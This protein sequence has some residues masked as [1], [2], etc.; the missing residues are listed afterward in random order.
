MPAL[1]IYI[2][3]LIISGLA[4]FSLTFFLSGLKNRAGMIAIPN[5]RSLHEK[6]VPKSGGIAIVI[7]WYAGLT[8]LFLNDFIEKNLYCAL[9][10][11]VL[12]S[13]V[14][15]LDDIY[16]VKPVLRL[17]IH[18]ISAVIAFS[19]LGGLRPLFIPEIHFNYNWI[20]YPIAII[21]IVWFIN[22]FNFMDGV[23]GYASVEAIFISSVFFIMSWNPASVLLIVCV[24]GFLIW[25][26]PK[27]RIFMGDTGSTQLGF[28]LV[29]SGIYFHNTLEFSILNWI[30]LTS[31]FWFD[32][33]ITLARRWKNN[34]NLSKGHRK[35][36]YQRFVRMGYPHQVV[37]YILIG[38]NMLI[39]AL[40]ILYRSH[41]YLQIPIFIITLVIYYILTRYVDKRVPFSRD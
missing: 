21:G 6:P 31:P 17:L 22:L 19:F 29:I 8:I 5:K 26:W 3:L 40:I 20:V 11:G 16:E 1:N 41:K 7:T 23:D 12:I 35:H 37:N 24:S 13:V 32:A 38:L 10:T 27:A 28:V 4:S 34:E 2:L 25:N 39:I 36:V 30:M 9:M 18:F 15:L 14:S 33:T